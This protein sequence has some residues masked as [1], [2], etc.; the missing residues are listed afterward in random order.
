V[1]TKDQKYVPFITDSDQPATW[2]NQAIVDKYRPEMKKL[3]Y[4]PTKY[5][6]YLEQLGIKYPT[7]R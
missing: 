5:K 7:V 3:Y 2:L 4:D 6:T 1:Q